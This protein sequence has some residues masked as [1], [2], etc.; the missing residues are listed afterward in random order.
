MEMLKTQR[1]PY[2][3]NFFVRCFALMVDTRSIEEFEQIFLL[4][5]TV[6]LQPHE[7]N[8]VSTSTIKMTILDVKKKKLESYM[9]VRKKVISKN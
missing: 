8:F 5:C 9:S 2:I 3:K 1:Y 4:T 7:D 6:A